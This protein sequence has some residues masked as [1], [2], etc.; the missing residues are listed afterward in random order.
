ML[1]A[2]KERQ[3]SDRAL[4]SPRA[5]LQAYLESPLDLT[6]DVVGWWGVCFGFLIQFNLLINEMYRNIKFSIRLFRGW[7]ETTSPS[8]DRL[9]PQSGHS[10]VAVLQEPNIVT[11]STE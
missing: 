10:L 4:L 6:D 1:A 9:H 2:V 8:K 11:A 5:E 7:L 3:E